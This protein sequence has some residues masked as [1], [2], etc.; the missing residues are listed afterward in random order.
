MGEIKEIIAELIKFRDARDWKQFHDSKNFFKKITVSGAIS[1]KDLTYTV[2][3]GIHTQTSVTSIPHCFLSG[4]W[5]HSR[6]YQSISL[7]S[8]KLDLF[9]CGSRLELIQVLEEN[10]IFIELFCSP[11]VI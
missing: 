6:I 2:K 8:R 7:Y 11:G 1:F 10:N 3:D 5:R 4:G 9:P